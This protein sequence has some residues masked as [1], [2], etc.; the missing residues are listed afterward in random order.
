MVVYY[1][2]EKGIVD[3]QVG[4]LEKRPQEAPIGLDPIGRMAW[5]RDQ[6]GRLATE[7]FDKEPNQKPVWAESPGQALDEVGNILGNALTGL[8]T[9]Y[10]DLGAGLADVVVQGASAVMGNGF[11]TSKVFDDSDNPWTQWRQDNFEAETQAG[12]IASGIVRVGTMIAT[13]PKIGVK[14]LAILPRLAKASKAPLAGELGGAALLLGDDVLQAVNRAGD[15]LDGGSAAKKATTAAMEGL[16]FAKGTAAAKAAGRAGRNS[17]LQATYK[18]IADAPEAATWWRSVQDSTKALTQLGKGSAGQKIRTVGEALGWDAF[19]AFNVY[20]EG[21]NSFDETIGDALA[22]FGI[23][24]W[25][26]R[27]GIEDTGLDRKWKQMAEG[28]AVGGIVSGLL[29]M[30]RVYQFSKAF[31]AAEPAQKAAIRDAFAKEA[32]GLGEGIAGL[33][34]AVPQGPAFVGDLG[35][36]G[37]LQAQTETE[38]IYGRYQNDLLAAHLQSQAA[39]KTAADAAQAAAQAPSPVPGMPQGAYDEAMARASGARTLSPADAPAGAL[40]G[41]GIDTPVLPPGTSPEAKPP[42]AD[43]AGLLGAGGLP[44]NGRIEQVQVTDLNRPIE[45][46][47]GLPGGPEARPGSDPAGLLGAGGL[48]VD[49]RIEQVQVTDLNRPIE[50]PPGLSGGPEA[51]PPG[52]SPAGLLGAGGG[53]LLPPVQQVQVTDLGPR[54]PEPTVTPQTIRN[55]FQEDMARVLMEADRLTFMEGPDGVMRSVSDLRGG[56]KQLMPRTRVDAMQYVMKH[57]PQANDLGV[58]PA[59]DSVW[60]N[61]ITNRG[62]TEGWAKIDPET[63]EVRFNRKSAVELDQGDLAAKQAE[64]M[65][66]LNELNR[67][68]EWL[69]NK[70][71][72]N[73]S[74]QMRP[75]VQDNL[76]QKEARDAYDNWEAEQAAVRGA[77]PDPARMDLDRQALTA[78]IEADQYDNAEE[79]RLTQAELQGITGQ[80]DDATVV[81]EYLGTTLDQLERPE[82]IKAELGRGWQVYGNDGELIANTTTK[83]AADKIADA[84]L[85]RG[86]E[87]LIG[88]ARQMQADAA[89]QSMDFGIGA[90]AYESNLVG[91]IK[92]TD[93]Q[94]DAIQK[95]SPSIQQQM[96]ADW[97]K[98]TGGQAWININDLGGSQKTF[99]MTQ[100]EMYDIVDG[101]KALLQ[102]GEITGPRARVLRNIADKMDTGMKLLAP[103]ARRQQLIDQTLAD[104]KRFI[105]HG[106]IC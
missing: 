105:E 42:G 75:E 26:P 63:M 92:L 3:D 58:I 103:Q 17:W 49:G 24:T 55:A 88:R 50:Y 36:L 56:V 106:D 80:L 38:R 102:T 70:E 33:S 1:D 5:E 72:V 12:E 54:A 14:G 87:A 19:V 91:K 31:N 43:P 37:R 20:G 46:P 4:V 22:E 104:A 79:L 7:Q 69:W 41:T 73:G 66:Q 30:A 61:F 2:P 100:G 13:L 16:D 47:P 82:V 99:E 95:F 81:R 18:E 8:G 44:V 53:E 65:D 25:L 68:E 34:E 60:M 94:I 52:A 86:Q 9:D 64:S 98:R 51:K 39:T 93:S 57:P 10:L 67:Y 76:A 77:E 89:D 97:E 96:R 78:G 32:G 83:K 45:Y 48:P 6:A 29:D 40:P 71:L 35:Q 27:T 28:V 84:E 59:A 62:L 101:I 85:R 74:P 23:N 21:D 90:P 15:L 11:D